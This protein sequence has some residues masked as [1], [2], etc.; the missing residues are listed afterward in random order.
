MSGQNAM[1]K[2]GGSQL[3]MDPQGH[4]CREP[5]AICTAALMHEEESP[6]RRWQKGAQTGLGVLAGL[7]ARNGLVTEVQVCWGQGEEH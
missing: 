6:G 4:L 1:G 7:P 3:L 5:D 2:A